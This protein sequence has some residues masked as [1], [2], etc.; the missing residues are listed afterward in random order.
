MGGVQI[1]ERAAHHRTDAYTREP[2]LL[3]QFGGRRRAHRYIEFARHARP[4]TDRERNFPPVREKS[5]YVP[6]LWRNK[7]INTRAVNNEGF[8]PKRKPQ[9]TQFR[10]PN[11]LSDPLTL[12]ELQMRKQPFP[13]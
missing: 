7:S 1:A 13:Y 9:L 11:V 12:P 5:A 4:F 10:L 3:R 8:Y 6:D 2:L